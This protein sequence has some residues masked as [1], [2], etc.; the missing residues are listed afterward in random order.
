MT[1]KS[2]S[3]QDSSTLYSVPD[4]GKG[5]FSVNA[6]G[7]LEVAPPNVPGAPKVPL[8]SILAGIKDRGMDLPVVLRIENLIDLQVSHLNQSFAAAIEAHDYQNVY[9]GVF[10][11]KVNQQS[12]VTGARWLKAKN[13]ARTQNCSSCQPMSYTLRM[14]K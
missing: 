3:S 13:N 5:V 8:M 7:L 6:N 14:H 1:K 11:I 9:R 4:W 12:Q 2:W 10:P